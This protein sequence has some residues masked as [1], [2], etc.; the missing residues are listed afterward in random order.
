MDPR[1]KLAEWMTANPYFAEASANR[2]WSYF[3]A[4]GIVE[5]VDDFRSTNPPTNPELLQALAKDFR[6]HGYDLKHLIRTI[7]Q[8]RT[9]QLSSVPND[10]NK[11]DRINYSHQLPRALEAAVLLDAISRAAGVPP[12][13]EYHE[14]AGGGDPPVGTHAVEMVPDLCPSVFMDAYHRSMRRSLPAGH[15]QP[16]LLEATDLIAGSAY[17]TKLVEPGGRLDL[18]LKNGASDA[19]VI[20]DFYLAALARPPQP[21][22]KEALLSYMQRRQANRQDALANIEWAVINSREFAYNH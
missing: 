19:Q 20:D 15:L 4:T 14:R 12:E 7:V 11:N 18:L 10:T 22:E 2:L 3:F 17:T 9:Y 8:S 13:L 6:D 5:P 21:E 1:S 16:N